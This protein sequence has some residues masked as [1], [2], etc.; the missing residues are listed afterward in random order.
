MI[1]ISDSNVNMAQDDGRIVVAS[2]FCPPKL[3]LACLR[4][5][6]GNNRTTVRAPRWINQLQCQT[7]VPLA[8]DF[9]SASR[10]GR[11][12][13]LPTW[14]KGMAGKGGEEC[15]VDCRCGDALK[16]VLC[17]GRIKSL[18]CSV[19]PCSAWVQRERAGVGLH[20]GQIFQL[21]LT[22]TLTK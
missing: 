17:E 9:P 20:D 13:T 12:T 16:G 21:C 15:D 3:G 19:D 7:S 22:F 14:R 6:C 8:V 5:C 1:N 18:T 4:D 2:T 10:R 11:L